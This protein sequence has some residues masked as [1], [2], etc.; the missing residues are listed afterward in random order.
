MKGAHAVLLVALGL[1][2][3]SA[4]LAAAGSTPVCI[5]G[6]SNMGQN[7]L[8]RCYRPNCSPDNCFV[9]CEAYLHYKDGN[10]AYAVKPDK[11]KFWYTGTSGINGQQGDGILVQTPEISMAVS[12][13]PWSTQWTDSGFQYKFELLKQECSVNGST[14][15][16]GADEY[17]VIQYELSFPRNSP[18]ANCVGQKKNFVLGANCGPK[19]NCPANGGCTWQTQE[20]LLQPVLNGGSPGVNCEMPAQATPTP[21]PES[22]P[23]PDTTKTLRAPDANV[24]IGTFSYDLGYEATVTWTYP[25]GDDVLPADSFQIDIVSAAKSDNS[26]GDCPYNQPASA[27]NPDIDPATSGTSINYLCPGYTYTVSVS[28]CVT[29]DGALQCERSELEVNEPIAPTSFTFPT[30]SSTTAAHNGTSYDG[31]APITS[32][33]MTLAKTDP[34]AAE[35]CPPS[36]NAAPFSTVALTN[37]TF[38]YVAENSA[39][40][41]SVT[42]DLCPGTTYTFTVK[43]CNSAGCSDADTT[44]VVAPNVAP[45]CG[46]PVPPVDR[47]HVPNGYTGGLYGGQ[48]VKNVAMLSQLFP[49][50]NGDAANDSPLLEWNDMDLSL[51][52]FKDAIIYWPKVAYSGGAG[53]A[54]TKFNVS[55]FRYIRGANGYAPDKYQTFYVGGSVADQDVNF[56]YASNVQPSHCYAMSIKLCNDVGCCSPSTNPPLNTQGT[57]GVYTWYQPSQNYANKKSTEPTDRETC[58]SIKPF[59]SLGSDSIVAKSLTTKSIGIDFG[60]SAT[61]AAE[62][63]GSSAASSAARSASTASTSGT[64]NTLL[65]VAIAVP[66]G[67]AGLAIGAVLAAMLVTRNQVRSAALAAVSAGS[68]GQTLNIQPASNASFD[69]RPR[70]ASTVVLIGPAEEATEAANMR[71]PAAPEFDV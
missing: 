32:Y 52:G 62:A 36:R 31:G 16:S 55:L 15:C 70:S 5:E 43:A 29:V 17:W 12:S 46:V 24:N 18:A 34:N 49:D 4:T 20:E 48:S 14:A 37:E 58:V 64:S 10:T 59:G 54:A 40:W 42:T 8:S 69:S 50:Q 7:E 68:R 38:T 6:L 26:I 30:G 65:A 2:A 11:M 66:V 22:T 56:A 57:V 39:T 51:Y 27:A 13:L 19:P 53:Q 44:V 9:N 1:L 67:I 21:G 28:A 60:S 35:S 23:G 3:F 41:L 25:T 33:T 45:V 71:Q 47:A 63:A 61:G